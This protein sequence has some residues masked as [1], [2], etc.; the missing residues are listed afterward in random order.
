MLLPKRCKRCHPN[1]FSKNIPTNDHMKESYKANS[2]VA[3]KWGQI[4]DKEKNFSPMVK[5]TVKKYIFEVIVD[6]GEIKYKE[7]FTGLVVSEKENL[8]SPYI[9]DPEPLT[10]IIS[11]LQKNV[12]AECLFWMQ[13][14]INHSAKDFMKVK[15]KI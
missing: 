11:T 3:A 5:T 1:N 7:V 13:E 9:V 14:Y 2:L 12:P 6:N 4:S 10:D 15:V 8:S